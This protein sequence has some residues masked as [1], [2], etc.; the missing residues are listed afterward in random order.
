MALMII[1]KKDGAISSEWFTD[2]DGFTVEFKSLSHAQ[3]QF[4]LMQKS[5][6]SII[7]YIVE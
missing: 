4:E 5:D 7:S 6:K 3:S 2:T 1:R